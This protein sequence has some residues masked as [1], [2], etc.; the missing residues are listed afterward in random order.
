M[1]FDEADQ[2]AAEYAAEIL[3]SEHEAFQANIRAQQSGHSGFR[4]KPRAFP[5]SGHLNN[6]EKKARIAGLK[7]RTTCRKCGQIG[8]W[9]DDPQ[10]PKNMGKGKTKSGFKATASSPSSAASSPKGRGHFGG[11]GRGGPTK[12]R[13]VFFSINEYDDGNGSENHTAYMFN[14]VPPPSSLQSGTIISQHSS[15]QGDPDILL[16]MAI[17]AAKKE[18]FELPAPAAP[19][20][21][22]LEDNKR[23]VNHL[24]WNEFVPGHPL[25]DDSDVPNFR[26]CTRVEELLRTIVS[27]PESKLDDWFGNDAPMDLGTTSLSMTPASTNKAPLVQHIPSMPVVQQVPP[28]DLLDSASQGYQTMGD[29]PVQ[30][31]VPT[32]GKNPSNVTTSLGTPS[33]SVSNLPEQGRVT[34]TKEGNIPGCRHANI[35]KVGSNAHQRV[36]KCKDCGYTEVEKVDKPTKMETGTV[37]TCKHTDKDFR[38]TTATTYK[39]RCKTCGYQETGNKAPGQTGKSAAASSSTPSALAT[40]A[41]GSASQQHQSL[42]YGKQVGELFLNVLSVHESLGLH[43]DDDQVDRIFLKCKQLIMDRSAR[44]VQQRVMVSQQMKQPNDSTAQDASRISLE[45]WC[46]TVF[47]DGV[48]KGKTFGYVAEHVPNYAKTVK[49]MYDN[50]KLTSSNLTEFVQF[51]QCWLNKSVEDIEQ[52]RQESFKSFMALDDDGCDSENFLIAVLDTGCN[53]TC[54]GSRWMEQYLR[55][56]G[57]DAPLEHSS[58]K[59]RGVGGRVEVTGKR[60]IPVSFMLESGECA[61]GC[62]SSVEL[63]GSDAPLLLSIHAQRKLGLVIDTDEGTVFSKL[64]GSKLSIVNRDGLPGIRLL[65]GDPLAHGLAFVGTSDEDGDDG[66][67]AMDSMQ[68]PGVCDLDQLDGLSHDDVGMEIEEL[69]YLSVSDCTP[70]TISKKKHKELRSC[71]QEVQQTDAALWST[72]RGRQC[73]MTLRRSRMLLPKGCGSFLLELFAGAATLSM[74]ASAWGFQISSPIDVV[75]DARY[76]MTDPRNRKKIAEYINEEDPFLLSISPKCAP[77]S[78]WQNYNE[79]RS[80]EMFDQIQHERRKWYPVVQWLLDIIADR[81]QRGREI[82]L[83]NPWGG[84]LWRLKCTEDFMYKDM[85]NH[86]TGEPVTIQKIDQCMYG[87]RHPHTGEP[88]RKS[89]GLML[90]S[91]CMKAVLSQTCDGSH[92]HSHLEGNLTSMAE[93]WPEKLCHAILQGAYEELCTGTLFRAFPAEDI[94]EGHEE[95][96]NLDAILTEHD[97]A[98]PAMKRPRINLEELD[99]EEDMQEIPIQLDEGE[100]IQSKEAERKRRWLSVPRD[101]RVAIRRLHCMTGHCSHGALLRMLKLAAADRDIINAVPHFRCQV[102]EETKKPLAPRPTKPTRPAWEQKFNY[103]VSIDVFEIKDALGHRHSILSMVDIA[104]KYH[105]AV[106]VAGGGTP[107]SKACAEALNMGWLVWAGPPTYIV[108]DQGVHNKGRLRSLLLSQGVQLRPTGI[109]SPWQLGVGERQGGLLKEVLIKAIHDRQLHGADVVALLCSESTRVKNSLMNQEGYSP[110]Q[111]VIGHQPVDV[112]SIM[113]GNVEQNM[114]THQMLSD[115]HEDEGVAPQDKFLL[116]LMIRQTAKESYMKIDNSQRITQECPCERSVQT[117]RSDIVLE[118]GSLV[119]TS[120]GPDNRRS[121]FALDPTWWNDGVDLRYCMPSG[122]QR[123]DS[124]EADS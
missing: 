1:V 124:S 47:T 48:H 88:H 75:Y 46:N 59:F 13:T 64:F 84:V 56:T 37:S 57:T 101:K 105:V 113:D 32:P 68:V 67:S 74:M 61:E 115:L 62:I 111:W 104:T 106:R 50:G 82:L 25:F 60:T 70:K 15:D 93:Q 24:K 33:A 120:Q 23:V 31:A 40:S 92:T 76:D 98:E 39:W 69:N 102:C 83:E 27:G 22:A 112:T 45:T 35:T 30:H 77:W 10:C 20:S 34:V 87:L 85:F 12:P 108:A 72:L 79:T 122:H 116:Q 14:A 81:L 51:Y 7:A 2:E 11:K 109:Y 118:E 89:T 5:N 42:S 55:L 29:L 53:N 65:P 110:Y 6:D 3:Q 117:G 86:L 97:I 41:A 94:G 21:L 44:R 80:P 36:R 103:E 58:G 71:F 66:L 17:E 73:G 4:P 54:H 26:F 16:E 95:A 43:A 8:H 52:A 90:S 121:Q 119:R 78:S 38:G 99:R 63:S 100:V 123:R 91:K 114:G 107:S 19:A 28:G 96:G 9:G 18:Q 49:G